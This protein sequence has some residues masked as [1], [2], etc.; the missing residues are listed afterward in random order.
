VPLMVGAMSERGLALAARHADVVGFSGL[1]QVAG[2]APGTFTVAS[3]RETSARVDQVRSEAGGRPY[4]SDALLQAIVLGRDPRESAAEIAASA[5]TL[6][7]ELVLD[8]PFVLLAR[9]AAHAAE[10]LLERR[11][12][13]GFDSFITHQSQL[14][15]LGEVI[16]A[17][18]PDPP[19]H[20]G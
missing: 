20:R 16:A 13:Y 6:T 18:S 9:D 10:L 11:A 4:R 7:A 2:E 15:A 8:S 14:E 1:L 17:L 19:D 3:A 12:A 5:P